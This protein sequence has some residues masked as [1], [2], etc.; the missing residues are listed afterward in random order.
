[1]TTHQILLWMLDE[2]KLNQ[3]ESDLAADVRAATPTAAAALVVPNLD[4][5]VNDHAER[6]EQSRGA[7]RRV[8]VDKQHQTVEFYARVIVED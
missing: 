7:M 2:S 5:L 8:F 4:D 6:I 1:M 3:Q